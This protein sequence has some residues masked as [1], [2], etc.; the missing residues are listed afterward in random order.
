MVLIIPVA[1]ALGCLF[2]LVLA[3]I[4]LFAEKE[5]DLTG[6]ICII[7]GKEATIIGRS[8]DNVSWLCVLLDESAV[9][10]IVEPTIK[11]TQ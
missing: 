2:I 6:K 8:L 11:G 3:V 4:S 5:E 1:L 9:Y 7:D 10:N